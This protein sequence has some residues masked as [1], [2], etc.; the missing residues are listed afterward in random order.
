MK[1]TFALAFLA[2]SASAAI[3]LWRFSGT[4]TS[5]TCSQRCAYLSLHCCYQVAQCDS[6]YDHHQFVQPPAFLA[7]VLSRP[8]CIIIFNIVIMLVII[9]DESIIRLSEHDKSNLHP[10][11]KNLLRR[12]GGTVT[13]KAL[14]HHYD[15]LP[16]CHPV[17]DH[18]QG[19]QHY[20][21][22]RWQ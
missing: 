19:V 5:F 7:V 21:L 16:H 4:L 11:Y 18:H 12:S 14:L 6:V 20:Q 15:Y 1:N 22:V 2:A 10:F 3:A 9:I 13:V 17:G 8:C